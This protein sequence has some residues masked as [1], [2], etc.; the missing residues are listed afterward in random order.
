MSPLAYVPGT[1]GDRTE[2]CLH[3]TGL[4]TDV[5]RGCRTHQR[6]PEAWTREDVSVAT[7][8]RRAREETNL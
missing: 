1:V 7:V 8:A 3:H 5:T 2:G 6:G 4:L